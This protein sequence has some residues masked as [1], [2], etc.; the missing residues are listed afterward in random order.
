MLY[1]RVWQE[2]TYEALTDYLERVKAR[3]SITKSISYWEAK[4]GET[5][6]NVYLDYIGTL[7]CKIADELNAR[8]T[9][10]T[11]VLVIPAQFL[12]VLY[13]GP[14]ER[15]ESTEICG[16]YFAGVVSHSVSVIVD[17]ACHNEFY[18]YNIT[19]PEKVL[20]LEIQK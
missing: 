18:A 1:K 17:P 5:K 14:I 8:V 13:F 19:D 15:P 3:T 10:E 12:P 20:K 2:I 6:L 16:P 4:P 7:L 9:E 11:T